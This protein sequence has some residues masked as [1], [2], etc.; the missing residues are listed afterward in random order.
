MKRSLFFFIIILSIIA[1]YLLSIRTDLKNTNEEKDLYQE[2]SFYKPEKKEEYIKYQQETSLSIRQSIINVNIGLNRPF[3]TQTREITNPDTITVLV[4]KY[5]YLPNDYVPSDMVETL[6]Y[7]K[8]KLLLQKEAYDNFLLMAKDIEKEDM[9]IRIVSAYRSFAYQKNL[10]NN[11]LKHDSIEMVDSYSAR[12][13]YSEHQTGLAIDIDNIQ[14]DYN[15]FHLTNEFSWIRENAHKY[16]FILRYPFN[17][18]KITGYKYEPWHLRYVG[19]DIATYIYQN[20][21]TYDEY[22]YEFLD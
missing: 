3:Y 19:I 4:N 15:K 2:Y 5:H 6:E 17:K 10:Y 1:I 18:E 13:G 22:Y 11:Y 16:G 21:I 20:D 8:T 9:H 7:A 12:P 14:I